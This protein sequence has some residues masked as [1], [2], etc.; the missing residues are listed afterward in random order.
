MYPETTPVRSDVTAA[1]GWHTPQRMLKLADPSDF[2]PGD[3]VT[4]RR[5]CK[6]LIP[7]Y[8]HGVYEGGGVVIDFGGDNTNHVKRVPLN[9]FQR[10][11]PT[12]EVVAHG[13]G[14][15]MSGYLPEAGPRD[16]ILARARFLVEFGQLPQRYNLPGFNCEH[17][18]NWCV[19]GRY[20][21]SH[22]IRSV[23]HLKAYAVE[24]P[25]GVIV[26]RVPKLGQKLMPLVV[27]SFVATIA[28][29]ATYDLEIKSFYEWAEPAWERY[30][31]EHGI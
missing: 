14:T 31:A 2:Q 8:H 28:L 17:V 27:A 6:Q 9:D 25:L 24:L 30:R 12:V 5:L 26:S 11:S 20:C 7:Y 15:M 10:T 18:A 13:R 4:V 29:K 21:E 22:Q 23:F 16:E 3:H 1:V 19:V